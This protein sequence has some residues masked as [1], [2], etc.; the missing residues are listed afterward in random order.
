MFPTRT[1]VPHGMLGHRLLSIIHALLRNDVSDLK[2]DLFLNHL[3][4]H[5]ICSHCKIPETSDQFILIIPRQKASASLK[6]QHASFLETLLFRIWKTL[7]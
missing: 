1:V 7:L 4:D 2:R 3:S 6:L 5:D